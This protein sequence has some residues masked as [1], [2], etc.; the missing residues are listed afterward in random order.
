MIQ[1]P[2][3][4]KN[5]AH[6]YNSSNLCRF[7]LLNTHGALTPSYSDRATIEEET[8]FGHF[9]EGRGSLNPKSSEKIGHFCFLH[10]SRCVPRHGEISSSDTFVSQLFYF[11]L[12]SK[13]FGERS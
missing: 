13:F 3:A 9:V 6:L 4:T 11:F 8:L 5:S 2:Q 12:K 10:D 7:V 1:L